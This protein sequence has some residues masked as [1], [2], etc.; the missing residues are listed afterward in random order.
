MIIKSLMLKN[1]KLVIFY[2]GHN[3]IIQTA[4]YDGRPGYPYDFFYINECPTWKKLI[5]ENSFIAQKF[6]KP[7]YIPKKKDEIPFSK[8]W[9]KKIII[10]V[11]S[12]KN[13]K[14]YFA[15]KF[16]C[17]IEYSFF[18]ILPTIPI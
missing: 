16:K 13:Q 1:I 8:S 10:L 3:E 5:I 17:N 2:V 12:K 18:S 9:Q 6:F 14:N 11:Q 7:R 4:A 15:T